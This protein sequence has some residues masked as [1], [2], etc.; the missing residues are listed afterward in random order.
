MVSVLEKQIIFDYSKRYLTLEELASK[1]KMT[2]Y[3]VRAIISKNKV[4]RQKTSKVLRILNQDG[5]EYDD[6]EEQEPEPPRVALRNSRTA[7]KH[8][9]D[10]PQTPIPPPKNDVKTDLQELFA[11]TDELLKKSRIRVKK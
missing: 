11:E 5:N 8:Q 9:Q 2:M 4:T 7:S 10:I 6:E 3:I 1:Y